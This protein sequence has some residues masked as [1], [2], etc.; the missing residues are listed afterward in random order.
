MSSSFAEARP[1]PR[2]IAVEGPIGVGKSTLARKLAMTLGHEP[3]LEQSADNPFLDSFYRDRARNA[4]ATQLHFL[5][6][7][8]RQLDSVRHGD[9]FRT[10]RVAD[11][12]I[13]K[14]RLFARLN[15]DA[16]EFAL[17]ETVFDRLVSHSPHPDLVIYLQAPVDVLLERIQ[18]RGIA[19]EQLMGRK[20]LEQLNQSYSEFFHYYDEAPL[21]IVNASTIDFANDDNHYTGL[22]EYLLNLRSGRQYFNPTFF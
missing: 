4:L 14:D 8:V 18:R 16:N 22:V 11:F 7:R 21:L 6:Q 1:V 12:L 13:E 15:L 2:F 20:Y 10:A 17:Y 9:L 3:L 5:T 19:A